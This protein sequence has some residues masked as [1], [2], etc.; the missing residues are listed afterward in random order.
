MENLNSRQGELGKWLQSFCHSTCIL[1]KTLCNACI[2]L[3]LAFLKP[4]HLWH[5]LFPQPDDSIELRSTH[6]R[7]VLDPLG[8]LTGLYVAGSSQ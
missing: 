7:A 2:I 6:V 3:H 4:R 5:C 8:R 1:N